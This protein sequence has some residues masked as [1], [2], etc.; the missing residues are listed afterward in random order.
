MKKFLEKMIKL[1]IIA[2]LL[3]VSSNGFI[4]VFAANETVNSVV[5]ETQAEPSVDEEEANAETEEAEEGAVDTETE[6]QPD[7]TEEVVEEIVEDELEAEEA[8][9]AV[10]DEEVVAEVELSDEEK[11]LLA[12]TDEEARELDLLS[13]R[14]QTR[15]MKTC[16][17]KV[18]AAVNNANNNYGGYMQV[19]LFASH[20]KTAGATR[21]GYSEEFWAKQV[22][23]KAVEILEAKGYRNILGLGLNEHEMDID[24]L[25]FNDNRERVMISNHLNAGNAMLIYNDNPTRVDK[26]NKEFGNILRGGGIHNQGKVHRFGENELDMVRIDGKPDRS[27]RYLLEWANMDKPRELNWVK[28]TNARANDLANLVI[29]TYGDRLYNEKDQKPTEKV[30]DLSYQLH[31]ANVGWTEF[32]ANGTEMGDKK[33]KIEGFKIFVDKT[34]GKGS[35]E[36]RGHVQDVGWQ[37]W[38]KDGAL[39]GS[40]GANRRMEAMQVKLTGDLA[41][42]YDVYYRLHVKGTGWLGWAK[43]GASAGTSGYGKEATQM[44]IK[45][46]EKDAAAP[47]ATNKPFDE[48]PKVQEVTYTPHVAQLGWRGTSKNGQSAGTTGRALSIEALKISLQNQTSKGNIEYRTHVQNKGWTNWSKN[49]GVSGTTGKGLRTEAIE[50]KLTGE[51]AKE[52]DVYYRV[53]SQNYGWLGWAKNGKPAGTSGKSLRAE[54]VEIV[55]VEKSGKAPGKVTGAYKK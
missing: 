16:P 40:A 46:V 5:D 25:C 20:Y 26:L 54:A 28:N 27:E 14:P 47:G 45:L 34:Q 21:G 19:I 51:M 10:V 30:K 43:N 15:G 6:E 23:P 24:D 7:P 38:S 49:G 32:A 3:L 22:V 39:A 11:S 31:V 33:N 35:I 53:H 37:I 13:L 29:N 17:A 2:S 44:Q 55:I 1:T 36:Y 4:F 8:S 41:K 9:T 50:I 48:K 12:L 42:K 18:T 52:Y